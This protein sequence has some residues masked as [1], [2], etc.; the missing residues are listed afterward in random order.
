[1]V[2]IRI[3]KMTLL[4][5]YNQ[6]ATN[7][8]KFYEWRNRVFDLDGVIEL[9]VES[10]RISPDHIV[11]E[12]GA[13]TATILLRVR[14]CVGSNREYIAVDPCQAMLDQALKKCDSLRTYCM[15]AEQFCNTNISYD[16]MII[17]SA[18]R[19]FE[20]QMHEVFPK[21]VN[22]LN[23][24]GHVV[25]LQGT[26]VW[27]GLT[28]ADRYTT[29][30][31][32]FIVSKLE[33]CGLQAHASL[34]HHDIEFLVEEYADMLR[35]RYASVMKDYSDAFIEEII[36]GLNVENGLV[37]FNFEYLCIVAVKSSENN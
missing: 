33:T 8:D 16:V 7:Y 37:K 18:L 20:H 4:D 27:P 24:G 9:V 30:T 14:D 13:G 23:D 22:Q 10:A 2:V 35:G 28:D 1:M 26:C 11:L 31:A 12:M 34:H 32:D 36:T 21:F 25:I 19:H 5:H 3:A 6:L 15:D 29:M 17:C